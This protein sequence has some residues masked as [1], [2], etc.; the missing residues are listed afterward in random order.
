MSNLVRRNGGTGSTKNYYR[1]L[2]FVNMAGVSDQVGEEV[3]SVFFVPAANL[4]L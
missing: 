2:A 4:N 1:G 3:G